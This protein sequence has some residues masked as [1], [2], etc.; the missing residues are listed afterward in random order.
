MRKN[1]ILLS[2]MFL[3]FMLSCPINN[4]NDNIIIITTTSATST[5]TTIVLKT[6]DY[7]LSSSVTSWDTATI[8]FVLTDRFYNGN[9]TNDNSYGREK[10]TT[11][12]SDASNIG[13]FHGGDLRGLTDKLN[14]G[15]FTDLGVTAIWI[16]SIVEQSHGWT[17]GGYN[18]FKHYGYHG[19]Y[20]LDFTKI[21]ANMGTEEDLKT[22][23]ETAHSKGIKVV[24]DVVMNH[25]GYATIKDFIDFGID[26][27]DPSTD[28]ANWLNPNLS[29]YYQLIDY[30][31]VNW[32]YWWGN[33]WVRAGVGPLPYDGIGDRYNVGGSDDLTMGVS[34]LPD[35]KTESTTTA[36]GLPVFYANKPD[37]SADVSDGNTVREYLVKWHTDWVEKYGIDGFRCDTAKHVEKESWLTLKNSANSSLNK[38]KMNNPAKKIDDEP[39]WMTAEVFDHGVIKDTYYSDASFDSVINFSFMYSVRNSLSNIALIDPTYYDYAKAINSDPNFNV[40]SYIS[41]HDTYLFYNEFAKGSK[42]NQ[43]NAGTLLLLCPG[44]IQIYYGD[45]SGRN[46]LTSTTDKDQKTRSD[47]NWDTIDNDILSHWKKISKFREKHISISSGKH[48]GMNI[49]PYIFKRE[50]DADKVVC[51]IGA[52]GST[53]VNVSGIFADGDILIDFYTGNTATVA[54]GKATFTADTNGTILIEKN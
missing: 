28:E 8:Y 42:V 2:A 34:Y 30:E 52:T 32:K 27:K 20:A 12:L 37:T 26:V 36:I 41:S 18:T 21:D 24:L 29:N 14:S 5:T 13:T 38:W 50:R 1:K 44:A 11:D 7:Q 43:K 40:L 19:Y 39:F 49:S 31:S 3:L 53:E 10:G 6:D 47:M 17:P 25:P 9:N 16:T 23:V 33:K 22:F 35:F 51:V 4:N 48:F 54:G 45:E 15:Y 46:V